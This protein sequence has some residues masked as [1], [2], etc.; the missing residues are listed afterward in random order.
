MVRQV[1]HLEVA[2]FPDRLAFLLY[3]G[4]ENTLPEGEAGPKTCLMQITL[5]M[6]VIGRDRPGL[7]DSVAGLIA[8]HG[9][10]WLDSRMARLGGQFAGILRV[11]IPAETEEAILRALQALK[12]EGLNVVVHSDHPGAEEAAR[13]MAFLEI[14]GQDRPGI[15]HQISHALAGHGV[16]VEELDTECESAAMSGETLFKARARLMIPESCD[17]ATLR[18]ELEKIAEDLIVDVTLK[19]LPSSQPA[20]SA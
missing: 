20:A 7:V 1:R 16:N 9:G 14:V 19:E 2:R 11:Q 18:K 8:Q 12:P 15:V 4:H 3:A 5:V 13:A 17:L 6:T 10:N